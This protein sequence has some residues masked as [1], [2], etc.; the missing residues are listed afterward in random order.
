MRRIDAF[1]KHSK[2]NRRSQI[3]TKIKVVLSG[4]LNLVYSALKIKPGELLISKNYEPYFVDGAYQRV[5]GYER[6]DGQPSPHKADYWKVSFTGI[7]NGP[8]L[9]NTVISAE[10]GE[11]GIVARYVLTDSEGNGYFIVTDL[12]DTVNNNVLWTQ[13][14][15]TALATS[16][17]DFEGEED[18]DEHDTS[19]LSAETIRRDMIE[20]VGGAESSGSVL[21]VNIYNN[22]VYAFRNNAAGDATDLWKNTGSGWEKI[23]LGFIVR[24]ESGSKEI[25]EGDTITGSGSGASCVVGRIIVTD[26]YWSGDD[27][28]GYL[29]TTEI[30]DGPFIVGENLQ[31]S[32]VTYAVADATTA[33]EI[34]TI[35]PDGNYYFRNY[36]F[37]GHSG[38]YRMHGVNGV[39]NAFEFDGTLYVPIETGMVND[40]PINIGI[41]RGHLLLAFTGGSLQMS[42]K[43]QGLS[44]TPVTGANELLTG[45]EITGF[46]EEMS[47]VTFVFTRNQTYRLEGF[48]QENIQLKLH[49]YETGAILDTLQRIGRSIYLDDRGF[50]KLST[51]DAFGDFA[52]NQISL[53]ID[54][55]IQDFLKNTT[56]QKTVVHR[57]KSLYRCFFAN[58]E[59]IVIGFSGNKVNGI[60]TIDYGKNVVSIINGEID[61]LERIFLG[62]DDGYVYETDVGRNFDGGSVEAYI[63]TAYG[64]AGDP[65][66][67]K[68]WRDMVLYMEGEG[69]A[70]IKVSADYDY[71]ESPQNFETIMDRSVF[72]GGG[73]YG[74]SRHGEFIYSA[75]SKTDIRVTMDSHARNV[76]IIMYHNEAAELPHILYSMQFH[77]SMRKIIRR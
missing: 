3:W 62:S 48:V 11:S 40:T 71:N 47:D 51:T 52:S 70:S 50:S 20:V 4:G 43:N 22:T 6:F 25:V 10:T 76:S 36:N 14:S 77:V 34:I 2:R 7:S 37:G 54:P 56:V 59:A 65:E 63:V 39:D 55:M 32:A 27:A 66:R 75:A 23:P 1:K 13:G 44:W 18:E 42:G 24:F 26:G 35:E 16:M 68:R 58:G 28:E 53:K 72:L 45:D 74:I 60:M 49:N 64:F 30:T 19:R 21:G 5:G 67:N 73:R 15:T 31:V 69:R 8:F 41:H 29:I 46:I 33:Q 9:L 57:G 61:G 17:S 38:T 12:S